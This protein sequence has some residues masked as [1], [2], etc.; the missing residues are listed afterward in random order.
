MQYEN[1]S[2]FA[3]NYAQIYSPRMTI[4]DRLDKAMKAAKIDSQSELQ[5][6][7][8]V[9][10]ATISRILK[11]GGK[12]GPESETIKKLAKA[13]RVSFEWLNEGIEDS[14]SN[15]A[16]TPPAVAFNDKASVERFQRLTHLY[17][18]L[19]ESGQK[20]ILRMAENAYKASDSTGE[21]EIS[22]E[23]SRGRGKL[24]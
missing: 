5:R 18:E 12:R 24:I 11:G 20:Q 17:W 4:G 2:I 15:L 19:P 13:C 9:P 23:L 3:S 8:G 16:G 6:L 21:K 22:N 14:A 10:Q 1:G 7:S